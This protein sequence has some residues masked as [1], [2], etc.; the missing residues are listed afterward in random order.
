M[1]GPS[2]AAKVAAQDDELQEVGSD[3][4]DFWLT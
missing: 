1:I 3:K 2:R 4:Y